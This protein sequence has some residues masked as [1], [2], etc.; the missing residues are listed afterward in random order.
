MQPMGTNMGEKTESGS[1]SP[2]LQKE[3]EAHYSGEEN[4]R[5]MYMCTF[6]AEDDL[7]KEWIAK[8]ARYLGWQPDELPQDVLALGI[9]QY[10]AKNGLSHAIEVVKR[11]L[12]MPPYHDA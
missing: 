3:L 4:F 8:F 12:R 5:K 1:L 2:F 10:D 9:R 7:K 11:Q 6:P